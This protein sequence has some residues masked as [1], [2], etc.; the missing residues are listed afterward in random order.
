MGNRSDTFDRA[1]SATTMGSPSDGGSAWVP[2][3]A[4]FWGITS[5][6]AY[7]ATSSSS[8]EATW[9]EASSSVVTVQVTLPNI[10]G[11]TNDGPVVRAADNSN[12]I[13]GQVLSTTQMLLY[14]RVAGSFTQIGS[15]YTGT[16]TSGD[17]FKLTVN[18][19]NNITFQQNGVTRVTGTDSAGS[20][21]TKH[22]IFDRVGGSTS[23]NFEDF[24][25][26]DNAAASVSQKLIFFSQQAV[27]RSATY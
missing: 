16:M 14:K 21:N 24:S 15:T 2:G 9:L 18:S 6:T 20:S 22:G 3:T 13:M 17:V 10:G 1:D 5:N 7:K 4:S 8:Y 25:I 12:F 19:S 23:L 11:T 27:N 26:T